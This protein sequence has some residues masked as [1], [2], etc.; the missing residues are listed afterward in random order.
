MKRLFITLLITLLPSAFLMA[1]QPDGKQ[2][3][4][5]LE[6]GAG[7]GYYRELGSSPIVYKG[8]ELPPEIKV[9]INTP[10]WRY[11]AAIS[12]R[13]G[14]YGY[15]I[16]IPSIHT[17]GLQATL[18]FQ[19]MHLVHTAPSLSL[20]A[21][22]TLGNL[23]DIRVNPQLENSAV[24]ISDFTRLRLTLLGEYRLSRWCFFGQ[25][26]ADPL[27]LLYRPGYSYVSN[28]DRDIASP[29]TATFDQYRLY[30][31][32]LTGVATQ[33]GARLTLRSGNQL[34]LLYDWR[35]LTSRT[36][37]AVAPWRFQQ[38]S[39]SLILQLLFQL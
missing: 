22:A 5:T 35:Y 4:L 38:A 18:G 15:R 14:A 3:F 7:L 27:A 31:A 34:G 37:G 1:Q 19:A 30:P 29:V 6:G 39:H 9:S 11:E 13:L 25:I 10:N 23:F 36:S 32:V 8:L 21:G 20:W 33:L 16:R 24:G 28:Y 12:I 2:L 26:W 17:F